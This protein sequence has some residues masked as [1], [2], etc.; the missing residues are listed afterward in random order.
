VTISEASQILGVSEAALRQWTDEGKIRAFITPGG[1]RRYAKA[2]LKR[3]MGS[4]HRVL[5]IKDLVIELENTTNLL[6]EVA[7][8][9]P[10]TTVWYNKLSRDSQ[11]DLARL[12]R[13]LLN[14]IVRYVTEPAKR[15]ETVELAR[16][17]GRGFGETLAKSGLPLINSVEAFILNRYPI[18]NAATHLLQKREAFTRRVVEAIPLVAQV[19]D[20]ALVS[21]VEAHQQ[22]RN[23]IQSES[24]GKHIG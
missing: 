17:V 5:G 19:M 8:T 15:E 22:Y 9:S 21:L 10:S 18:M 13:S 3:F 23:G 12:G 1:H 4:H 6:G 16:D 20:E 11:E 24:K 14:L 7:R 2:E